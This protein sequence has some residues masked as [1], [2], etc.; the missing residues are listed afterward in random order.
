MKSY[1][2]ILLV[3]SWLIGQTQSAIELADCGVSYIDPQDANDDMLPMQDTLRYLNY[4]TDGSMLRNFYVD[5][6][7]FG[8]SQTDRTSVYAILPDS[9]LKLMGSLAFGACSSCVNGFAFLH[10]NQLLA[11]NV[12]T[13]AEMQ[14]W[15][16]SLNQPAFALPGNLQTLNGVGRI[17]GKL[18]FCAIGWLVEYSVYS[19]PNTASTEFSTHILCPQVVSACPIVKSL[20]VDCQKDSI[21]LQATLPQGCFDGQATARW[22]NSN[23]WMSNTLNTALPVDGN[24]GMYYLTVQDD[25]CTVVDS[26]P[27]A[28]A[29]FAQ[30]PADLTLCGGEALNIAGSGGSGHFWTFET[31]SVFSDSILVISDI[32][33][34][35]AGV[36]VLHAFN[37]TGCEDT[38]SIRVNVHIPP[39]PEIDFAAPCLGDTLTLTVVNT[40]AYVQLSWLNPQGIPLNPAIVTNF[41]LED[42]GEYTLMATDTAGCGITVSVPVNGHEP[43]NLSFDIEESC[44]SV[45]VYGTPD[46]YQYSWST[47]AIGPVFTTAEGNTYSVTVTD[48]LGCAVVREVVTPQPDGPDVSIE[49]S[50]PFCPGDFGTIEIIPADEDRPMIFSA[51]GGMTYQ[52]SGRFEK[53]LPGNYTLAVQDVLGCIQTFPASIL[54][55]DTMGVELNLERLEVRPNT[56]ISLTATTVGNIQIW[57]WLPEEID[58]GGPVTE[59]PAQGSLDVR[60][61]VQDDRGCKA[62]DGFR[63]EVVLGD[64][65]APNAF[66]PNGDGLNDHFTL[67]SDNA[68]GEIIASMKIFNRW[69]DLVFETKEIPLNA[70]SLGWN[71]KVRGKMA[72]PG[73]YTYLAVIRFGNG[74]LRELKG[75]VALVR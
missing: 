75:D 53:L 61:V 70:E 37:E 46:T 65:Y 10:E 15:L 6:N 36:Y 16:Q 41:Q 34:E 17:S 49:V 35:D 52:L 42:A 7:A 63:L 60:I 1:L 48:A 22:S 68:S 31:G 47:G 64:T 51:D 58:S 24:L 29:P 27:A 5:I 18:P 40:G 66:S 38:D 11:Q 69:G 3:F 39:D 26:L 33:A 13:Q 30:A 55:P 54:T 25:C 56:P 72:N 50:H 23:G 62:S 45:R 43:P 71:G 73:V 21:F 59:F 57:Q 20:E 9:T 32:Q 44:D 14:M 4:F 28:N 8:G 74:V 19:N 67:Y 12:S 2:S